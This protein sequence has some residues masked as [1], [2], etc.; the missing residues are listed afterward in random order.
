M[1]KNQIILL[2]IIMIVLASVRVLMPEANFNPMGAIALMGGVLFGKRIIAYLIPFGALFIGDLLMANSSPMY[3]DYLF[4][5]SFLFVYL[6]FAL[7]IA[8]GILLAKKPN[9]INVL[10]GSLGAAVI[11]FLV[12]NFGS[13]LFLTMYPKTLAGLAACMEAGIPFFRSTLVSQVLFSLGIFVVYSIATRKNL[14]V[15]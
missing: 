12:S 9:F 2:A 7:I 14:A 3:S 15:V 11:F 4:S 10:G 8:L 13:W 1:K 5:T 6:A